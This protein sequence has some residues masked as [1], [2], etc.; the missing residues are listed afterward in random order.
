MITKL[1][2]YLYWLGGAIFSLLLLF[3]LVSKPK[4]N[5]YMTLYSS[6]S[7]H[8]FSGCEF[9]NEKRPG[10][11]F[12]FYVPADECKLI[13]Y[14]GGAGIRFYIDYPSLKVVRAGAKEGFPIYFYMER[15][16]SGEFDADRHLAGKKPIAVRDGMEIY[17]LN[18]YKERKF[19]GEDGVPVYA[20][21]YLATIR[22]SRLYKSEFLVFY[23]YPK[24]FADV[25]AMDDF[26][27]DV[28]RKIV[29]E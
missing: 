6:S 8:G 7:E 21:D 3:F 29:A 26:A 11:R 28:L 15:I 24:E 25:K 4:D 10:V 23:Q 27:L 20:S 22:A 12:R 2:K 17:E 19:N 14:H 18:D 5:P 16:S 9:A 1:R 13:I